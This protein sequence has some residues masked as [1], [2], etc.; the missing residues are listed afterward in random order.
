MPSGGWRFSTINL[1]MVCALELLAF[2]AVAATVFMVL[3]YLKGRKR[4]GQVE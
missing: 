2:I 4:K 1:K 3:P